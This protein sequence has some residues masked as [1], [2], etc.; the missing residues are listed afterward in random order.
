[1]AVIRTWWGEKF[2]DVLVRYMD[3]GRLKRGRSYSG[4]HRL[5]NFSIEGHQ[6]KAKVRGNVNPYFGVY[7]EPQY[8][9]SV[10]LQQFSAEDWD[11]IVS[12]M[13]NNA[14]ILSQLL[15]NEMP[16]SIERIFSARGLRLLPL[17]STDII[18]KCSCPDYVSPCKHVAGVYY[19]IAS[20]LDRDPFLAFQLRGMQFK[21]LHSALAES[22]LGQALIH[23][24]ET[25]DHKLE[26]HDNRFPSPVRDLETFPDLQSFWTGGE[27]LPELDD[28]QNEPVT[29]AILIKKGGDYPEFWG[30]NK[31]LIEMMEPIYE[32]IIRVNRNSI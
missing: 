6:V 15:L 4:S 18:S 11:K 19:K 31:P 13:T 20:I 2:L 17:K 21:K 7:K 32:R 26:Y 22:D 16:S 30:H 8:K 10:S 14:A 3:I 28:L 12:D 25:H 24:M 27:S 23:Q 5:L 1:M 9:V 29:A